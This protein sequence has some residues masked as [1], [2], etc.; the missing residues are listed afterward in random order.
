MLRRNINVIGLAMA[1]FASASA[2]AQAE[3]AQGQPGAAASSQAPAVETSAPE[4]LDDDPARLLGLGIAESFNRFGPPASVYAV[5]GDEAWQDDVAFAYGPGYTL[6]L[7]G[8]KLWQLRLSKPYMGSI[9]GLFLGD[10][11]AKA[12][13]V[14]GQ[15]F[16][17]DSAALVYRMP[18]KSYPVKLRLALQDDRIVDAY[19]YRADF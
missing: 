1:L 15:P 5:R 7:Y 6:F 8:N 10:N 14:L 17:A 19:L 9:Y 11:S 18:Y 12:L 13:S 2:V 3:A 16:E 4:I